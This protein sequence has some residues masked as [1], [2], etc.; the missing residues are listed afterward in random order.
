MVESA[1]ADVT[2][3][4]ARAVTDPAGAAVDGAY[5]AGP[6]RNFGAV[7]FT[8]WPPRP[9]QLAVTPAPL[10]GTVVQAGR[11][12]AEIFVGITVPEG[13]LDMTGVDL[14]YTDGT[15]EWTI[16]VPHALHV[17]VEGTLDECAMPSQG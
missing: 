5:A 7:E 14:T 9:A 15:H 8:N 2:L 3:I 1:E 12:S 10:P 4:S 16:R 17:C 11:E 6:D 13:G